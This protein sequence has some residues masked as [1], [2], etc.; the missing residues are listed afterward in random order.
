MVLK[1]WKA[2]ATSLPP[3][4]ARA[5]GARRC[6]GRAALE[7]GTCVSH[8]HSPAASSARGGARAPRAPTLTWTPSLVAGTLPS[9]GWGGDPWKL[10]GGAARHRA[11][12][13][14]PAVPKP[15]ELGATPRSPSRVAGLCGISPANP[16][17]LPVAEDTGRRPGSGGGQR[18]PGSRRTRLRSQPVAALHI[19]PEIRWRPE[20]ARPGAPGLRGRGSRPGCG[21]CAAPRPPS[22]APL[23]PPL[24]RRL[25]PP[26]SRAWAHLAGS[27]RALASCTG[28]PTPRSLGLAARTSGE[29]R[30]GAPPTPAGSAPNPASCGE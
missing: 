18:D 20:G 2:G 28:P 11:R 5:R 4:S 1:R 14:D 15:G 25:Q 3:Q 8:F 13:S 23:Q 9:P 27:Q 12:G 7:P 24:P 21:G 10:G 30:R 17:L 19:V 29:R 6:P 22:S 16:R 26:A